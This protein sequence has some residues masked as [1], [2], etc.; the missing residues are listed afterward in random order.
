VRGQVYY[1]QKIP[2]TKV[3]WLKN[4]HIKKFKANKSVGLCTSKVLELQKVLMRGHIKKNGK[5]VNMNNTL[6][7][8]GSS[9]LSP[10][11]FTI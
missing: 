3:N 8:W 7:V 5:A 10:V 4:H 2:K 1:K 6:P 11:E 9:F